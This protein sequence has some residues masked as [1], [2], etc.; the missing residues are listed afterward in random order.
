MEWP[1]RDVD[2][3][4]ASDKSIYAAND[5]IADR[6][7]GDL[8][9][10]GAAVREDSRSIGSPR[11][12]LFR[13]KSVT[14]VAAIQMHVTGDCSADDVLDMVDHAAK[15]GVKV[16]ALPEYAFGSSAIPTAAEASAIADQTPGLLSKVAAIAARYQCLIAV[17]GVERA[18]AGLY[19]TTFLI[20]PD[21][22]EIGR[23]RKTH[24]TAE[25]RKWAKAGDDYPVFET[26]FGRIGVMS[27]Y[28]AVF[29]E[30][31]RCLAIS[32]ADIILW[33][34]SL[35]EPFERELLAIPRAEDNRVAVVLANR[36][37]RPTR[38]AASSSRRTASRF[39]ISTSSHRVFSSSAPSCRNI[40]ISRFAGRNS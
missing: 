36:R 2:L 35:R 24:L 31:S 13:R 38:A 39:G 10:H 9:H 30:T 34:A 23:Y 29:P 5:K 20:G 25:E 16:L 26:P 1:W 17:P 12:R 7:P 32:A 8:R 21:G 40:S 27:G 14:K 37:I 28:D 4:A 15:L 22:T 11:G 18:A 33:P 6:R 3:D 19:V